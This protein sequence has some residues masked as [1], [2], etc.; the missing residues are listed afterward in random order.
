M[1]DSRTRIR[2]HTGAQR[3]AEQRD[4]KIRAGT[5]KTPLTDES[6]LRR[7]TDASRKAAQA[8]SGRAEAG[9]REGT[10]SAAETAKLLSEAKEFVEGVK[11][12]YADEASMLRLLATLGLTAAEFSHE[13]GMTFQAVRLDFQ[14]LFEIARE[15][16]PRDAD[17]T[18]LIERARN[19]VDRLDALSR[20]VEEFERGMRDL[21]KRAETELIVD[22]PAVDGLYSKPMHRAEVASIL[23]NF[24]SNSLK[25]MK[26]VAGPRRILVRADRDDQEIVLRS[27]PH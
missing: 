19:M 12:Q 9:D 1:V 6:F 5:A 17:V 26:R 14:R 22:S 10:A 20:S 16:S 13:T 21:A 8:E 23:L 3:I 24:Y 4:R 2:L 15:G 11:A 18:S 7:L 25:A 27:H